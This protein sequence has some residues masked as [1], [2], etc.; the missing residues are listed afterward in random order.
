MDGQCGENLLCLGS[1]RAELLAHVSLRQP[2]TG[3]VVFLR[4]A[5]L[6]VAGIRKSTDDFQ[7]ALEAARGRIKAD[8]VF[9]PASSIAKRGGTYARELTFVVE[10]AG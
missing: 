3:T 6:P 9:D 5:P 10:V 2:H 4:D 1:R 8:D 7:T